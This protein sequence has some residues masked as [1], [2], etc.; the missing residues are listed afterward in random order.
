MQSLSSFLFTI[1]LMC[2]EEY[3]ECKYRNTMNKIK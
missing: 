1:D 3:T 2:Y